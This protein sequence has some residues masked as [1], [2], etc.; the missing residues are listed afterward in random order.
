MASVPC[1]HPFVVHDLGASHIRSIVEAW[2]RLQYFKLV[3]CP[4]HIEPEL[5][6]A[7]EGE[8]LREEESGGRQGER[9][10][11]SVDSGAPPH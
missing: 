6:L 11:V 8:H 2:D 9:R 10:M 3:T 7:G 1:F 5:M 4:R